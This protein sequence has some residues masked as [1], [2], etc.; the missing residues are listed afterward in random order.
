MMERVTS[1]RIA[2]VCER[3]ID[4]L[5]LEEFLSSAAFRAWFIEASGVPEARLVKFLGADRSVTHT[6]G[7]SD[8]EVQFEDDAGCV[9]TLLIEN[10]VGAALQPQQAER[11][12]QRGDDYVAKGRCSRYWPVIVAPATYFGARVDDKGFGHQ[13][14]Y[15][16]LAN[17]FEHADDLAERRHYKTYMLRSAIEKAVYGYRADADEATTDFFLAYWHLVM[18]RYPDL[19]MAKP[20]G[21]PSGSGRVY[22]KRPE[23]VALKADVAHKT[24]KGMVDLHLRGR[25]DRIT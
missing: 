15:E 22:F 4:L 1:I 17:W 9:V 7:E 6:T 14:T 13:L 19:G 21:R 8:L 10:K 5:L 18:A 11:Y 24:G 12:R 3:D 25:G 23:I 20:G 16:A 2:G